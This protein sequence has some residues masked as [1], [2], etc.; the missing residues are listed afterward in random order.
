MEYV[1]NADY[2]RQKS[3]L[4]RAKNSGD[5]LKVLDAVEKVLDEW[6]GKAWPDD[7]SRWSVAL[8]DAW[9]AYERQPWE[10]AR[11]VEEPEVTRFRKTYE[12][13]S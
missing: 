6:S 1:T 13:I 12:R 4:T 9:A 3:A 7:W 11:T 5:P 10:S 2:R 8:Y